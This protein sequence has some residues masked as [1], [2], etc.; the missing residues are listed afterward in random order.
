MAE[1]NCYMCG[2]GFGGGVPYGFG[3]SAFVNSEGQ[4]GFY[5]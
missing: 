1:L 3:F 2:R 4:P 5:S